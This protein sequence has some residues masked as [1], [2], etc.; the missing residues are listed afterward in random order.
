VI[1]VGVLGQQIARAGFAALRPVSVIQEEIARDPTSPP[2]LATRIARIN[3]SE[4]GRTGG[5]AHLPSLLPV[6][7]LVAVDARRRPVGAVLGYAATLFFASAWVLA[8]TPAFAP[9]VPGAGDTA[10]ALALTLAAALAGGVLARATA[11][12]LVAPAPRQGVVGAPAARAQ[13]GARAQEA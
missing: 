9:L 4:P 11:D 1:L 2:A 5:L 8:G 10:A 13:A 12:R 6:A 3:G 7:V